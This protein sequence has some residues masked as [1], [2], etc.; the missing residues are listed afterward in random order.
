MKKKYIYKYTA[1]IA[2]THIPQCSL[3][4]LGINL[5]KKHKILMQNKT[6][7]LGKMIVSMSV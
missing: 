3:S 5:E 4:G 6:S 1:F 2:N 7:G